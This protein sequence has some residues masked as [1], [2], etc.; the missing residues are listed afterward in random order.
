MK[1]L[2]IER[3]FLYT[4]G[5]QEEIRALCPDEN[6][7][8]M[9]DLFRDEK[10]SVSNTAKVAVILNKWHEEQSALTGGVKNSPLTE[11]HILCMEIKDVK[12]LMQELF[13][14]FTH[15]VEVTVETDDTGKNVKS[16]DKAE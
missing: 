2:G 3:K 5:A 12:E 9:F 16:R 10:N 7:E 14:A 4:I 6:I 13:R 11:M 15:G 8:K 1:I